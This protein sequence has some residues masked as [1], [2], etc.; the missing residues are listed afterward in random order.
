VKL[1]KDKRAA[2]SAGVVITIAVGFLLVAIL[3]PMAMESVMNA[4]TTNWNAAV[5]TIFQVLLPILVI[6]GVAIR[7]IPSGK[8]T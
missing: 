6:I 1:S 3:F 4:T 2:M 8:G 7:Y 5:I